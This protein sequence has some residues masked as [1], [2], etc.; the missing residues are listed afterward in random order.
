MPFFSPLYRRGGVGVGRGRGGGGA[1]AWLKTDNLVWSDMV[2]FCLKQE[3]K[4]KKFITSTRTK[5]I[6]SVKIF[7][8]FT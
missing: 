5:N 7:S 4:K 1:G 6:Y 8:L 3:K 2:V